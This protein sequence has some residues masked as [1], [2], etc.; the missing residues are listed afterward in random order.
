VEKKEI[1]KVNST[2]GCSLGENP[3]WLGEKFRA[4]KETDEFGTNQFEYRFC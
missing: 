4:G 1:P 3:E 2:S